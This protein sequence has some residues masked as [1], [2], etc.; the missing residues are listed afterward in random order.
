MSLLLNASYEEMRGLFLD[1]LVLGGN[2]LTLRFLDFGTV[3]DSFAFLTTG[4]VREVFFVTAFTF[5]STATF[6]GTV[7]VAF[8]AFFSAGFADDFATA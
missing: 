7:F 5:S 6:V 8:F 2:V 1:P 3:T 4:F